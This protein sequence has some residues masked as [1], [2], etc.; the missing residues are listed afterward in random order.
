MKYQGYQDHLNTNYHKKMDDEHFLQL[1]F[2]QKL[3]QIPINFVARVRSQF[4]DIYNMIVGG[5]QY[6]IG[7]FKDK[8]EFQRLLDIRGY[9]KS[10]MSADMQKKYGLQKYIIIITKHNTIFSIDTKTSTI[11]WKYPLIISQKKTIKG[12]Q[13]NNPHQ[14]KTRILKI[15]SN[16]NHI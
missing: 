4:Q 15:N 6:V 13:T 14:T 2:V 12:S 10:T 3:Q 1:S 8:G 5:V 9:L 7:V 16:Q 11:I